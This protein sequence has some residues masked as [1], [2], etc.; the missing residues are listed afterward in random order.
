MTSNC[1]DE[2]LNFI[3]EEIRKETTHFCMPISLPERLAIALR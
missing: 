2:I 3:N 1:F